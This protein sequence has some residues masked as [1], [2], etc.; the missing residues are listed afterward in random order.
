MQAPNQETHESANPGGH[1]HLSREKTKRHKWEQQR[2]NQRQ[3]D[4]PIDNNPSRGMSLIKNASES[5]SDAAAPNGEDGERRDIKGIS[6][7]K[8]SEPKT[9]KGRASRPEESSHG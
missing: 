1:S 2:A 6:L 9:H 4:G 7:A 3:S 8:P 5:V